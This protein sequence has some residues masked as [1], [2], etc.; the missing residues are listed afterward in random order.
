[1]VPQRPRLPATAPRL[2]LEA[3]LVNA[4]AEIEEEE[5]QN[6]EEPSSQGKYDQDVGELTDN[7][8]I[9]FM[10]FDEEESDEEEGT[11]GYASGQSYAIFTRSQGK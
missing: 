9:G 8:T 11:Q 4:L 1:H 7:S 10:E 5:E 3:P 2:A 6:Y